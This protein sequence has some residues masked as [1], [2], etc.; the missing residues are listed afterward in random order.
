MKDLFTNFIAVFIDTSRC[1]LHSRYCKKYNKK[2]IHWAKVAI[3]KKKLY[4]KSRKSVGIPFKDTSGPSMNILI[5]LSMIVALVIAPH[6]ARKGRFA[7]SNPN[8]TKEVF[9]K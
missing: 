5:K 6:I 3:L 2:F 8:N 7:D 1:F 4:Q 9:Y